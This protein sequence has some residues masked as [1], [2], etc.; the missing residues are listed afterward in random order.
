MRTALWPFYTQP[1]WM[2]ACAHT[3]N[4]FQEKSR[5]SSKL[6]GPVGARVAVIVAIG[7]RCGPAACGV[8][9]G[10]C[11]SCEG[12][13]G[14]CCGPIAGACADNDG[15]MGPGLKPFGR[16]LPGAADCGNDGSKLNPVTGDPLFGPRP[17]AGAPDCCGYDVPKLYPWIGLFG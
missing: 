12:S 17:G 13:C 9:S 6:S 1:R 15:W 16:W 8:I 3:L 4:R 5:T 7:L 11:D 2:N 10:R 14:C